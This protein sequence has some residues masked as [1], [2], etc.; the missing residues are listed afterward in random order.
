MI[1]IDTD[2]NASTSN[3]WHTVQSLGDTNCV[4]IE[5]CVFSGFA[6]N[7]GAIDMYVGMK[8]TVRYF[9]S[10]N[11]NFGTHGYDSSIRSSKSLECYMGQI[12]NTGTQA[13][14]GYAF[15]LRGGT[16][17]FWSNTVI[18][19]SG[20]GIG[21][22]LTHQ[23]YRADTNCISLDTCPSICNG[24][25]LEDGNFDSYG[26][27][28]LDQSGRGSFSVSSTW[29]SGAASYATNDYEALEPVYQWNN[30]IDGTNWL[31]SVTLN[32]GQDTN[33]VVNPTRLIQPNRDYYDNIARPGYAPLSYP[34]PLVV[35]QDGNNTPRTSRIRGISLMAR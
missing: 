22:G 11:T 3:T 20:T 13:A 34:H 10:T 1:T 29:K 7:D 18:N 24:S 28:G 5:D 23:Y 8:A 32:P 31:Q 35:A 25:S 16:G 33:Y 4:C 19:I 6:P 12:Y 21:S 17:V 26:Y 14:P 2:N 9:I 15:K 30:T 27:P